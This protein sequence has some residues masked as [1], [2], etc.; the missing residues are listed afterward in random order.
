MRLLLAS[1]LCLAVLAAAPLLVSKSHAQE[2]TAKPEYVGSDTC[3]KCHFKEHRYWKK[4]DKLDTLAPL[5]PVTAEENKELFDK[6]TAAEL[7]PAKD[8]SK[9]AKC[10]PC[11]TTGYGK[12]GGY[13]AEGEAS[14]E[15]IEM[16]GQVG[17]ESCHGP[18]SLYVKH[19]TDEIAKD[20]NAKF[21]F[22]QMAAFGLIQPDND[23]CQTCHNGEGP[24]KPETAFEYET[25]KTKV[26][27]KQKKKK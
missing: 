27:S 18:G 1:G 19:K 12:P 13:P 20:K 10:L 8:Y 15:Q 6:R 2:E 5:R 23:N 24:T 11:H 3:K 7:D 26:H 16:F 25:A 9:D 14:A 21:T 17:C 4:T 22:E